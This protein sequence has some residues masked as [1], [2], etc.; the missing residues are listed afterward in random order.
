[1]QKIDYVWESDSEV[2]C[3]RLTTSARQLGIDYSNISRRIVDLE[4]SLQV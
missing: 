2:R 3:G 4:A 1:V